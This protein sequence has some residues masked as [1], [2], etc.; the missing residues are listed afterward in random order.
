VRVALAFGFHLSASRA[1]LLAAGLA[2]LVLVCWLEVGWFGRTFWTD[3]LDW[4]VW[5]VGFGL[6]VLLGRF[7]RLVWFGLVWLVWFGSVCF[8]LWFWFA[9]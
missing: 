1:G 6:L 7:G 2:G 5:L 4:L 8:V 3:F 9:C